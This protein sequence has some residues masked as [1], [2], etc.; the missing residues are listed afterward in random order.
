MA[1]ELVIIQSG[2]EVPAKS[3]FSTKLDATK[4]RSP[5]EDGEDYNYLKLGATK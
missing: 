2:G 5:G 3:I 4:Y 1:K